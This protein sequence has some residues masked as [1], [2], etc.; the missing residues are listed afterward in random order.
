[1]V[2]EGAGVYGFFATLDGVYYSHNAGSE[3]AVYFLDY[4]SRRKRIVY[5]TP[6]PFHVGMS[7]SPDGRYLLVSQIDVYGRDLVVAENFR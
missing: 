2:L 4:K 1:M 5:R 3:R 7:V 6:K